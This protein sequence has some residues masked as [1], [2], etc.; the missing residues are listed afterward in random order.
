ML[1]I[2]KEKDS[3][4]VNQHQDEYYEDHDI[5]KEISKSSSTTVQAKQICS[6]IF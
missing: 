2:K 3:M 6:D 1:P 4:G 5:A